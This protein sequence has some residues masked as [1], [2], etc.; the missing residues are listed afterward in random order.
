MPDSGSIIKQ[1]DQK[2]AYVAQTGVDASFTIPISVG[3]F[4]TSQNSK[5]HKKHSEQCNYNSLE[6]C[7]SHVGLK[8]EIDTPLDELSGG[9]KQRALIARALMLDPTILL[10]DEPTAGVDSH[11]QDQFYEL[12]TH[13]N[14]VHKLSTIMITHDPQRQ[15]T[16]WDHVIYLSEKLT[17]ELE[18]SIRKNF[19]QKKITIIQQP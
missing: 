13:F 8:D 10:L 7:L 19:L 16:F 2:I 9:Q 4:V 12:I 17:S 3:E 11:M 6:D 5:T 15:Y 18:N 1:K 14:T